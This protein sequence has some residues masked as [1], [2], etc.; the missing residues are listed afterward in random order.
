MAVRQYVGARYVPKFAEPVEWQENTA[1][2]ALTIV[3]YNNTSYT[4][5][6]P[7]PATVGTPKNNTE[8]WAKTGDYNA[9]VEQYRQDV[10]KAVEK[11]EGIEE[12]VQDTSD[13]FDTRVET[14]LGEI[15][16]AKKDA[17]DTIAAD[18][19]DATEAIATDKADALKAIE[20]AST[21]ILEAVIN[22]K[23]ER[24]EAD[25]VIQNEVDAIQSVVTG[26]LHDVRYYGAVGDGVTDDTNAFMAALTQ[27]GSAV[28]PAGTFVVN[29][30]EMPANS[31]IVGLGNKS[32]LKANGTCIKITTGGQNISSIAIVGNGAMHTTAGQGYGIYCKD[33]GGV[34]IRNVNVKY[35]DEGLH[36]EGKSYSYD[37]RYN[38][39]E[40]CIITSNG[41]YGIYVYNHPDMLIKGCELISN[42][43]A[44]TGEGV[45]LI[46]HGSVKIDSCH[47]WCYDD[48]KAPNS[49]CKYS[50]QLETA[51]FTQV[52]NTHI[53]GALIPLYSEWS[54]CVVINGCNIYAPFGAYTI[55]WH[56]SPY[57]TIT[58][59]LISGSTL[60]SF[61]SL[62]GTAID[63]GCFNGCVFRHENMLPNNAPMDS[64]I[65]AGARF[66][67]NLDNAAE[68]I[69]Y[70]SPNLLKWWDGKQ[71]H[72]TGNFKLASTGAL[73]ASTIENVS[74]TTLSDDST[75]TI[76]KVSRLNT[77]FV[78]IYNAADKTIT[79]TINSVSGT[80]AANEM[81]VV[82]MTP[83]RIIFLGVN[84]TNGV[85]PS[86]DNN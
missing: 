50:L 73:T 86:A 9:Q 43:V 53:E 32:T 76:P 42:S 58:N 28:V 45:N 64:C 75:W 79:V 24:I 40:D 11:V 20:G 1:Y 52:F 62:F 61:V 19:T 38:V 80:I 10:E 2:E 84:S 70:H 49:R 6:I 60:D 59:C 82:A 56:N 37:G 23:T 25:A 14:A 48:N 69:G 8:Y 3:L 31:S 54:T 22:E 67:Y 15:A 51:P 36:V 47:F 17:T 29:E 55:D 33:S 34:I 77:K 39:V 72:I 16:D 7:V 78:Y 4:S 63:M 44:G 13:K 65:Y 74:L 18:K 35:F 46:T 5:K 12:H 68:K 30:L 83:S 41:H 85:I 27:Q 21:D 57:P 26:L 71:T 81:T 66:T